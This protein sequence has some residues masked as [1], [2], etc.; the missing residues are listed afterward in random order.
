MK[1]ILSLH[2]L[3]PF[4]VVCLVL[5]TLT[6]DP[7]PK[8]GFW[9]GL[10]WGPLIIGVLYWFLFYN[11]QHIALIYFA[12]SISIFLAASLAPSSRYL[13][14]AI[15][16]WLLGAFVSLMVL[17]ASRLAAPSL[18]FALYVLLPVL[19]EPP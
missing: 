10:G 14:N 9:F 15:G 1:F 2:V 6:I 5:A 12:L 7:F 13:K 16:G 11:L 19:W 18:S 3:G 4:V 8:R 17:I